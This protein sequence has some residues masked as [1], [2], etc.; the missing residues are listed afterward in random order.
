MTMQKKYFI[1]PA[2]LAIML[3]SAPR[4]A[5]ANTPDQLD[6]GE[7]GSKLTCCADNPIPGKKAT[8][9]Y[10]QLAANKTCTD[11][12]PVSFPGTTGW[13][14]ASNDVCG[15]QPAE[16]AQEVC[17]PA[18]YNVGTILPECTKCG[19]CTIQDF[20]DLFINLYTFG[21]HYILAPLAALFLIIGSIILLTATGYSERIERGRTM[22]T[23]TI[24]GIIVVLISWVVIDTSIFLLT[25]NSDRTILGKN[26]Y[27][28]TELTYPCDAKTQSLDTKCSGVD[29]KTLKSNLVKLGYT[30]TVNQVFDSAT[31]AAVKNFQQDADA[32]MVTNGAAP[33]LCSVDLWNQIFH[34]NWA[35]AGTADTASFCDPANNN[36]GF[37]LIPDSQRQNTLLT[38]SGVADPNTFKLVSRFAGSFAG[39]FQTKCN[40]TAH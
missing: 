6:P 8:T 20:V 13:H 10:F 7:T 35:T 2:I 32:I 30:L 37:C 24:A 29:V 27:G 3:L 11:Y 4:S 15:A 33:T 34:T 1:L 40:S 28:G 12:G 22:I 36:K 14:I 9:N 21:L 23:Q 26:W 19:K 38:A 5:Q 31:T 25:G 17:D 18:K 39:E 16:A